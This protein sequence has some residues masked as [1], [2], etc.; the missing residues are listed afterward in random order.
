MTHVVS[1]SKVEV[2]STQSLAKIRA[3]VTEGLTPCSACVKTVRQKIADSFIRFERTYATRKI[4]G[5]V[6]VGRSQLD[7]DVYML[8]LRLLQAKLD[9]V[10]ADMLKAEQLIGGF[11]QRVPLYRTS[12]SRHSSPTTLEAKLFVLCRCLSN[13]TLNTLH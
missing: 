7:K 6:G 8:E 5:D 1:L 3:P 2:V 9:D 11:M 4:Y 13:W 10:L 12:P